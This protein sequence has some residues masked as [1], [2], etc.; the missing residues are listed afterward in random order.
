MFK[1]NSVIVYVKD[2]DVSTS[3]Y[4]KVLGYPPV[5]TYPDFAVFLLNDNFILGLQQKDQITPKTP[6]HFGG[7]ELS[8]SN[9]FYSWHLWRL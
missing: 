8:F 3:F 4:T 1:P 5:E 6:L 7:F 9:L 2:V